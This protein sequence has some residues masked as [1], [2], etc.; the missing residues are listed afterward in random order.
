MFRKSRKKDVSA[1]S[2]NERPNATKRWRTSTTQ[3][4]EGQAEATDEEIVEDDEKSPG[5]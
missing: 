2:A 3:Q 4:D 1:D 5:R